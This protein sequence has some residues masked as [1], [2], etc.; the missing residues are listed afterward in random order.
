MPVR[1][2]GGVFDEQVLTGSLSHWVVCGADF[3]GAIN[4]YGQPVPGS[5]AEIIFVNISESAYINIMNPNEC[6]L[7][8]ALEEG[9][10]TWDEISLTQMV[11]S[12]GPDVGTDHIDC[13]VCTVKRVPYIWGCNDG[14]ETFLDLTDTPDS[15]AG[16]AGY[17]VQVNGTEDGLIFTPAPAGSNAFAFVASPLQPTLTAVGADTLTIVGGTNVT[18]TTNAGTNELT[19]DAGAASN[20]YIP[21]P[22]GSSLSISQKYFVTS[23][24]T[25]TLPALTGLNTPGQ[26]VTITKLVGIT[27]LVDVGNPSDEINTDLG[28]TDQ[29]E[30]DATQELVFVVSSLNDWELQIG[31]V[32]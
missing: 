12:L 21:V 31:S 15:Y 17:I 5:A 10:S 23:A 24:G 18:I 22:G 32:N 28:S 1:Q 19:I 26:S 14:A 16:S 6:N 29:I 3:S 4:S 27:V 25:V 30:F 8:F 13:S 20:D 11:Q 2:S 7:S 9:R